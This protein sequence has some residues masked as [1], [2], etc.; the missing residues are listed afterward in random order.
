MDRTAVRNPRRAPR[1]SSCR[2][3]IRALGLT[4]AAAFASLPGGL[5]AQESFRPLTLDEAIEMALRRNPNL[6]QARTNIEQAEHSRLSAW[7]GFLPNLGLSYG[8]SNSSTGRLDPTGQGIVSTSY[9]AQL[10]ASYSLFDGMRRFSDLKAARLGVV[11]Q[12]ASYRQ[13]EFETIRLVKQ[14]YFNAV[15]ARDLVA[16]EER[17]VQRQEDQLNF[18]EQQL[19]LGRATRSDLLRSQVD[20]NNARLALLN[21][22]NNARTT[23][24]RLTEVV[25]SDQRVGPVEEAT[26]EAVPLSYGREQLMQIAGS[27]A[28]SLATAKAALDAAEA[29]VNSARSSYFPSLDFSAGYAWRNEEFP[30]SNRSWS[31]S[32]SGSYPL[33]NGFQRET[34]V[35]QAR[36]RADLARASERAAQLALSA[37]LDQ[38]YS[39]AQSASAGIDLAEQSVELS[40]ESLRVEQERYR[41]GLSTILDLQLAQI[42]LSQAEVDLVSRR[43]DYQLALAQLESLLG[44]NLTQP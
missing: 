10:G 36:A 34:Q 20:L 13:S 43:F 27:T 37:D 4:A 40:Q 18:V 8:Y 25:G 7:G 35:Y 30:P 26:L 3:F 15:A 11:Q 41:L 12:Q 24:F 17:R 44:Q 14:A 38:A 1:L 23:T 2:G 16:V 5:A 21:A 29:D 32:L 39:T 42:T 6:D 28:P 19:Q 33:F 9:S 31:L 22:E